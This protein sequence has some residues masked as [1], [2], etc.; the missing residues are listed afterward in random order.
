MQR[1]LLISATNLRTGH[2]HWFESGAVAPAILA[3]TALP[4]IFPPVAVDG[5]V[6]VDGGVVNNVPVS[7][8]V[9]LGARK[10][11]VLTCGAK[12]LPRPVRGPLDV[13]MQAVT[14][15][16]VAAVENELARYSRDANIV[17]M[18]T[19]DTGSIRFNDPSHSASLMDRA[20][21]L[22][23]DY[24]DPP[25]PRRAGATARVAL[26]SGIFTTF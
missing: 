10:I 18:P 11:Y 13:F 20:Y 19:F 22:S 6:F 3:S 25:R 21:E 15:S 16:R 9:A 7:K 26:A 24:L 14:H 1:K 8:A 23:R 5:N 4:G 2:E 17:V 12:P